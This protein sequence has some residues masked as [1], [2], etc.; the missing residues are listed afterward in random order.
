MGF[1]LVRFFFHIFFF[2]SFFRFNYSLP[3]YNSFETRTSEHK[4]FSIVAAIISAQHTLDTCVIVNRSTNP[5]HSFITNETLQIRFLFCFLSLFFVCVY[6]AFHECVCLSF[7]HTLHLRLSLFVQFNFIHFNLIC[8]IQ[9]VCWW[10]GVLCVCMSSGYKLY[11]FHWF[12]Y[13]GVCVCFFFILSSFH[14]VL[15]QK[16]EWHKEKKKICF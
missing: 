5:L 7:I 15:E 16:P 6:V 1:I 9:V 2:L 4:V 12:L 11:Y 8:F 10:D 14:C 3:F 13:V